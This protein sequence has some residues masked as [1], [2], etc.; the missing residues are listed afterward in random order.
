MP[1]VEGLREGEVLCNH[2]LIFK[3]KDLI[4]YRKIYGDDANIVGFPGKNGSKNLLKSSNILAIRKTASDQDKEVAIEFAKMLLSYDMQLKMTRDDNFNFSVRTDVLEEQINAVKT[5]E[6]LS[7]FSPLG[8]Y[9]GFYV[10]NLDNEKNGRELKEL[11][12]KSEPYYEDGDDFVNILEEELSEYFSG[13]ITEDI[14]IDRLNS[15]V[16]LYLKE[17]R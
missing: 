16:G 7:V 8:S 11:I 12:E 4:F 13:K 1:Y 2:F 10:E 6:R 14:L 9:Q 3:P 17:K 15:R 5:G